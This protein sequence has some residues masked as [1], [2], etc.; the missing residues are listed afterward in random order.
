[1]EDVADPE[2]RENFV[3]ANEEAIFRKTFHL[4]KETLGEKSFAF[5]NK[6]RAVLAA[7]FSM[8][9][10]E[11]ITIGLQSVINLLDPADRKQIEVL[12]Q[13]LTTVKLDDEFFALTAG[14]GKNSPGL[15]NE[16]IGYVERRLQD[17]FPR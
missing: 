16:R 3:Y 8:Y 11:A 13:T 7:G 10:F 4:L 12:R 5:R 14:G 1:M 9:H 15:L 17:A 6:A 2:P